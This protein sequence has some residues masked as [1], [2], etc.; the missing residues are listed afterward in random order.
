MNAQ[1]L[2]AD[3]AEAAQA[4][5]S[6]LRDYRG[7]KPLILAIP[8]GA[9]PMG[10]IIAQQLDGDLDVVLVRKLAAP[11]D[12][13]YAIGAVDENGW[14]YVSAEIE[15]SARMRAFIEQEKTRQLELLARR[16]EQYT[17]FRR[18][19]DPRG[20]VAIVIDDGLATGATMIAALHAVRA[21]NPAELVC[22]VP[23]A[24]PASI[25]DVMPFA[26]RLICLHAPDNFHAVSQFYRHFPQ[27]DDQE[28]TR[29]LAAP[30]QGEGTP[31]AP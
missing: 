25:A 10:N 28:V 17:P 14:A 11:F 31:P 15:D 24:P 2:F 13:E 29:I 9:V 4:L 6:R 27:V 1:C 18:P 12:P 3:R 7:R 23:L 19:I 20:R 30:D 5:A 22:A 16:R 26:D 8:R 21:R